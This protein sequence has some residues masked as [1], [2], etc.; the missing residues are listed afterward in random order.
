DEYYR[1]RGWDENG[2]PNKEKL[3]ELGLDD[4]ADE[5]EQKGVYS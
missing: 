5:L 2:I 1:L 3:K 4:V